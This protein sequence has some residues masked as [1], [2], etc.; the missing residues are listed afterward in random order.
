[1]QSGDN[2]KLHMSY[3]R[4]FDQGDFWLGCFVIEG[5]VRKPISSYY[6]HII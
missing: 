4:K 3:H 2:P 6:N 1:M 5:F